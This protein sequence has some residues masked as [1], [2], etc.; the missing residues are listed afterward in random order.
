MI[1]RVLVK[2]AQNEIV[3][4]VTTLACSFIEGLLS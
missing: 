1:Q 4:E 2:M 3:P